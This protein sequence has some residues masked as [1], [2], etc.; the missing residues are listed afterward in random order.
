MIMNIGSEDEKTEFKRSSAEI[1]EGNISIVS[2]LNKHRGGT[3]YFGVD[4]DGN[5]IGQQIG[6]NTI[7]N[8]SHKIYDHVK[9][10]PNISVNLLNSDGLDYIKVDFRGDEVPYSA[11]G[12][13]YMRVSDEDRAITQTQLRELFDSLTPPHTEW[14]NRCTEF[15]VDDINEEVLIMNYE[16][17]VKAG[18]FTEPYSDKITVLKKLNLLK[19]GKLTN[20]GF[21]L[22][23]K[24]R[25]V[26]L[27]LALFATDQK[28][29][30]LDQNHF[31]G[32]IFE[33]INEGISFISRNIRWAAEIGA[34]T[35]TDIPEVPINA[36]REIVINSFAHARYDGIMASHEI[37]IFPGSISVFNPGVLPY[38]VDP[39]EYAKGMGTSMPRNPNIANV[40]F[41]CN[42]IEAFGSGFYRVI[43]LCKDAG[44]KYRYR[45]EFQG[46]KFEFIRSPISPPV[47]VMN[48]QTNLS[49]MELKVYDLVRSNGK[50]TAE[51]ISVILG[52][53]LRT[54]QRALGALKEKGFIERTG[55]KKDG[56]WT[57]LK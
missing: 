1:K 34:I 57:I 53:T 35:R 22:F 8:I 2:I 43:S 28:L 32:N 30:F 5:I 51:A 31:K 12:R 11:D 7:R 23:S 50:L 42:R 9:P 39:E 37:D 47:A 15:G 17:G 14:E 20:A 13:Y 24:D 46:F 16:A 25:P 10:I 3:L 41:R 27:K 21:L 19:N 40:L 48:I 6:A 29:T 54:I 26:L 52:K 45:N 4:N 18:R 56:S 36:I 38:G 55:S 49:G 33:C 44:V